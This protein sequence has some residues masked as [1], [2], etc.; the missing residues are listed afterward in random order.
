[1]FL[2]SIITGGRRALLDRDMR[3][4]STAAILVIYMVQSYYVERI[5]L[6]ELVIGD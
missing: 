3:L 2:R 6:Q 4:G 5:V 1:M